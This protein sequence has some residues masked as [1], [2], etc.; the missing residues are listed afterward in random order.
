MTQNRLSIR[1]VIILSKK[2]KKGLCPIH[3][4]I[5]YKKK[6]KT[7]STS[8]FVN[9]S[10]WNSKKQLASNRDNL[11]SQ[12]KVIRNNVEKA[13]LKLQL[14]INDF[15]VEDIF[16]HYRGE[17]IKEK[18]LIVG[19]YN[20]YLNKLEKVIGIDLK[21]VTYQKYVD[22]RNYVKNFIWSKYGKKDIPMNNLNLQ[23]L[24]DFDYYLKTKRQQKQI[25]I[26]KQIQRLRKVVKVA[27]AEGEI[28]K[29][30]FLIYKYKKVK[31]KVIYLDKDE[32]F[33]L[34][35]YEFS[36]RRLNK[37]RDLFVFCCYTGL[38]YT[39]MRNLKAKHIIEN[40]DGNKWIKI[41]RQKTGKE[42]SVPLLKKAKL[43]L[44]SYISKDNSENLLPKISNQ[45]FNSYLKEIAAIIGIEKRLTHHT[46]RK[47]FAST[48]LLYN[49]VPME[50]VSEL[51]GHSSMKI[52]QKHYGKIAQKKISDEVK[53]LED[54]I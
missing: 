13:Y 25:T 31:T 48:V 18:T 52:T 16:Q 20:Y 15:D 4:R 54:K 26:N 33:Q 23:F 30:P 44:A 34:E 22:V 35:N 36:Q 7:F 38:P 43:I 37:V 50:I 11:N 12:L 3:C 14:E 46:A 19:Y 51:L 49:D 27:F 21:P 5:T 6:R 41:M 24:E 39:E 42:I 1:F 40:F 29:D 10:N 28:D 8:Q 17:D 32:L 53:K 9:P 2:N 47:T 45:K